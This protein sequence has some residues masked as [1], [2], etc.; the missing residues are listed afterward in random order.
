MDVEETVDTA[1]DTVATVV[2]QSSNKWVPAIGGLLILGAGVGI[3]YIIG[4]RKSYQVIKI[5]DRIPETRPPKVILDSPPDEVATPMKTIRVNN[6]STDEDVANNEV[7]VTV[8][9][10]VVKANVFAAAAVIEN[11]V[12]DIDEEVKRRNPHTPYVIHY[13]EFFA[14]EMA[15]ENYLQKTLTYYA[16]DGVLVDEDEKPVYNVNDVV[17]D[18]LNKFGHGST[19]PNVVYVRNMTRQEEYEVILDPGKYETEILGLEEEH[20]PTPKEL[21]HSQQ[22]KFPKE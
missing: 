22:R 4:K 15:T 3:G 11:D 13:D 8:N 19:Q 20:E 21:R 1:V 14:E 9:E 16:G 18:C 17:G 12:W 5:G 7:R 2:K 10:E 6:T